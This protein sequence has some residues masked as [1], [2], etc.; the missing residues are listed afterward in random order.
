MIKFEFN[1]Y[2]PATLVIELI[3]QT[4]G[5]IAL[6]ERASS[7]ARLSNPFFMNAIMYRVQF[8]RMNANGNPEIGLKE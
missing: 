5:N 4:P 2:H 8:I 6:L 7:A 3:D 1:T